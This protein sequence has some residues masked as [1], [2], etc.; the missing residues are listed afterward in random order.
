MTYLIKKGLN[1]DHAFKIMEAVRKG[2]VAKGKEPNWDEYVKEMKEHNVPDWYMESCKKI[3]YMFP[4]AHAVAY[5]TMAFRIAWFKVYYPLAY[6][7]TY[8]SIRAD[9]FDSEIMINGKEKV[10][11]KMKELEMIGNNMSV[12]EKGIYTILEIVL[13]MYERG[14][15]FLPIDLYKSHSTKFLIEDGKIRPP[16]AS[17]QGLRWGRSR[18]NIQCCKRRKRKFYVY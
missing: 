5:V 9:D 12:K 13:E 1:P 15:D 16:L 2:K 11:Q 4:K 18:G 17:I 7:A 14:F 6:Y 8:F 10:K 3:K